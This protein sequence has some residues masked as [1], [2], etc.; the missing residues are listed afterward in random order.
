MKPNMYPKP[1]NHDGL[2]IRDLIEYEI[3]NKL[4]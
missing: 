2:S 1:G 4:E 3:Q